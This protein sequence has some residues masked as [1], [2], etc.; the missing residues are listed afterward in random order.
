MTARNRNLCIDNIHDATERSRI[1]RLYLTFC[2]FQN[3]VVK[4]MMHFRSLY[5]YTKFHYITAVC[6]YSGL[7]IIMYA[8]VEIM[9]GKLMGQVG[10]SARTGGIYNNGETYTRIMIIYSLEIRIRLIKGFVLMKNAHI[11]ERLKEEGIRCG[12][13]AFAVITP[14]E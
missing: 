7:Y 12:N 3:F 14:N 8:R 13:F 10:N 9:Q 6:R 11:V 5:R 2:V 4:S 1:S